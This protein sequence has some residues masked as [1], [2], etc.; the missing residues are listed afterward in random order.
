MSFLEAIPPCWTGIIVRRERDDTYETLRVRVTCIG[1]DPYCAKE[2]TFSL[3]RAL[4]SP[5]MGPDLMLGLVLAK[6]PESVDTQHG[7]CPY[8]IKEDA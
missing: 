7:Q 8:R 3:A 2:T 4:E 5:A 1:R 6:I